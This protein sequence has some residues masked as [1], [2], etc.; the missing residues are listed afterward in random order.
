MSKIDI[1]LPE[2]W[3]YSHLRREIKCPHGVGHPVPW[4]NNTVHGCDKCCNKD[5][6]QEIAQQIKDYYE[7]SE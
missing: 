7:V 6:F 1:E 3:R 4:E 2:G 5:K